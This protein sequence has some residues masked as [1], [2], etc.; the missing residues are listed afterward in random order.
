MK[1]CRKKK[2]GENNESKRVEESNENG[3]CNKMRNE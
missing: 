3:K 2:K 1:K